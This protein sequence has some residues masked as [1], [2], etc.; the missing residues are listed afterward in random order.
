M[1][2][3]DAKFYIC[4]H[5]GNIA[6]MIHNS[7]V[8][9]ICCGDP[10]IE[11]NPNTFDAPHEKHLPVV[12]RNGDTVTVKVSSVEHP[13]TDDH[14]ISWIYLE[15][16]HGGQRKSLHPGDKPEAVFALEHDEPVAAFAYCN[17]HSLWE[18]VI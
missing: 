10:L 8:T 6:G 16:E 18:T 17:L 14:Y 11:L 5:C 7:G 2:N 12:E 4:K 1:A 15:T 3:R 9:M 13:M